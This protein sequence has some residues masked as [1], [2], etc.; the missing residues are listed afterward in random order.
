[1][2]KDGQYLTNQH[3]VQHLRS[4]QQHCSINSTQYG[5]HRVRTGAAPLQPELASSSDTEWMAL[6]HIP[7]V[8]QNIQ[9]STN[10]NLGTLDRV[11]LSPRS[12]DLIDI[13]HT[14]SCDVIVTH[15]NLESRLEVWVF[16]C[17]YRWW[18]IINIMAKQEWSSSILTIM[19]QMKEEWVVGC[20]ML[21]TIV[22]VLSLQ[23]QGLMWEDWF[24]QQSAQAPPTYLLLHQSTWLED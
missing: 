1:M 2:F 17:C 22:Q 4:A 21:G 15:I 19:V 9:R 18:S 7:K 20:C 11:P 16:E 6:G 14:C 10:H 3:L 12:N 8:H 23:A 24:V 5:S 13:H